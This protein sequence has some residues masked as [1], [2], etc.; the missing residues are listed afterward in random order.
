MWRF[1]RDITQSARR[2]FAVTPNDS[3]VFPEPTRGLYI[4]TAGTIRVKHADDSG[5]TDYSVTVAGSVYPWAV[6]QVHASGTTASGI[7]AQL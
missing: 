7:V 4:G 5:T 3:T 2:A 1:D 6:I